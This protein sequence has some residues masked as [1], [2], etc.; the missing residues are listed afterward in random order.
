M[1]KRLGVQFSITA[2]WRFR[3]SGNGVDCNY[4]YLHFI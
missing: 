1:A 3:G 2:G 4:T